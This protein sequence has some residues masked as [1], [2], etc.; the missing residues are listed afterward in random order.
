MWSGVSL[1]M[2]I[3][4]DPDVRRLSPR[5][6]RETRSYESLWPWLWAHTQYLSDRFVMGV[7]QEERKLVDA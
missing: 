3:E 5:L 6:L 2:A 7:Q 4:Q 1:T